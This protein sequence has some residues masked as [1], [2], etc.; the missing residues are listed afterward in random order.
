MNTNSA[1]AKPKMVQLKQFVG[2]PR[3]LN[4][5]QDVAPHYTNIGTYLLKDNDGTIV[6]GIR[7]SKMGDVVRVTEEIFSQW[8]QGGAVSATWD[9][10][11][12]CLRHAGR[13]PLAKQ[14]D[15]CLI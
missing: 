13:N 4:I 10:L 11:I 2:K 15:E 8:L 14:I 6:D 1:G 9:T 7:L 5:I 3:K 12:K